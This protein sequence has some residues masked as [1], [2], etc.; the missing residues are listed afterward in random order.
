MSR[1]LP[2]LLL[3][4]AT[5]LAADPQARQERYMPLAAVRAL[6]CIED[7][8]QLCSPPAGANGWIGP[9]LLVLV[10]RVEVTPWQSLEQY[11]F[12]V[13]AREGDTIRLALAACT[14]LSTCTGVGLPATL[15]FR[16]G[17]APAYEGPDV[18]RLLKGEFRNTRIE[19]T[20]TGEYAALR[21]KLEAKYVPGGKCRGVGAFQPT[22]RGECINSEPG[23]QFNRLQAPEG[24]LAVEWRCDSFE[25]N[26]E[27]RVLDGPVEKR[28]WRSGRAPITSWHG[29]DL[30]E[31][32]VPCGSP[33]AYSTFY[34]TKLGFSR[35]IEFVL[36][37]SPDQGLALSAGAKAVDVVDIFGTDPAPLAEL[38]LDYS[39]SVAAVLV[40]DSASFLADGR[41][42]VTYKAGADFDTKTTTLDW[43]RPAVK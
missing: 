1:V 30:V 28:A 11:V 13:V 2:I 5:A 7:W 41:I 37:V 3:A 27:V 40:V 23:A 20:T 19:L 21:A 12:E 32:R 17:S 26:C 14:G 18:Y 39:P 8:M 16:Q 9:D 4:A 6:D 42:S 43:R 15:R 10:D 34:S 38:K 25:R 33:C 24:R 31:V 22:G 29:P 36:D 35:P